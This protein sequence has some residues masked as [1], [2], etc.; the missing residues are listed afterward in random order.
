VIERENGF[1]Y[2]D[3]AEFSEHFLRELYL[4][5]L[6][7][8]NRLKTTSLVQTKDFWTCHARG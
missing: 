3:L 5:S 7:K 2:R 4:K 8:L 6:L 1:G